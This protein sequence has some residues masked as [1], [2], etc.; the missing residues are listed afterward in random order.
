MNSKKRLKGKRKD[1][2]KITQ[3]RSA[4]DKH[5]KIVTNPVPIK[6]SQAKPNFIF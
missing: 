5:T 2:L 1:N 4:A 6:P 3:L